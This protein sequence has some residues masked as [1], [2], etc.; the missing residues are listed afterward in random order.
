MSYQYNTN[1]NRLTTIKSPFHKFIIP[2]TFRIKTFTAVVPT[3]SVEGL[4]LTNF[5][6]VTVVNDAVR[7]FVFSFRNNSLSINQPSPINSTKTFWLTS[8]KMSFS[9]NN[10]FSTTTMPIWFNSTFVL[11]ATVNFGSAGSADVIS[12]IPQSTVNPWKFYAITTTD[13]KYK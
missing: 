2:W 5:N 11:R 9:G 12:T 13:T 3:T 1:M 7:G 10:V 6:A 8:A 4:P